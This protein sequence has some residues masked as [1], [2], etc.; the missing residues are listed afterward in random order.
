MWKI[1]VYFAYLI[2]AI[3]F[4]SSWAFAC[5]QQTDCNIG[6]RTYRIFVPDSFEKNSES[7]ALIHLHGYRGTANGVMRNKALISLVTNLNIPLIA[8]KSKGPDWNFPNSPSYD[9]SS[10]NNELEFFEALID[11]VVNQFG[12]SRDKLIIS[13][14]SSGGMAVWYLA[15]YQGDR[16]S[17]YIPLSGT[18]W[19]DIPDSCKHGALIHYHGSK[20]NL[21]H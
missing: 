14:F 11:D 20:D 19:G 8:P 12:I 4:N 5:G 2:L 10:N 17:A 3:I 1:G 21:C 18:F 9:G 6:D 13:G 15:C 16:Y 7:G